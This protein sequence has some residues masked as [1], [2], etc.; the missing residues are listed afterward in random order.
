MCLPINRNIKV[1]RQTV[2][3]HCNW[4][5]KQI[6]PIVIVSKTIKVYNSIMNFPIGEF[7][8]YRLFQNISFHH[9]VMPNVRRFDINMCVL[10]ICDVGIVGSY[11]TK[12]LGSLHRFFICRHPPFFD[13]R[14][15]GF[16]CKLCL[17]GQFQVF[18][19]PG[20]QIL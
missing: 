8:Y 19:A 5:T 10:L 7:I 15:V 17:A 14:V 4:L 3:K 16:F 1:E 11:F 20:P 12:R 13:T 2:V 18:A 9:N 6:R